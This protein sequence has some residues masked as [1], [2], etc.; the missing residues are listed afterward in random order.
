MSAAVPGNTAEQP[1]SSAQLSHSSQPSVWTPLPNLHPGLVSTPIS[2]QLVNQQLVMA[3]L[4]NQQYAVNRLLAQQ[5]LNQQYLN[6]PPPVS[7]SMNKPLE[8]QL[9]TNTEVSFEI[10]QWYTII[11][12]FQNQRYYL[13]HHGKLKDNSGLEV[14]VAEYKEEELLKDLEES[15]QDKN[16]NTL[17]SVKLEEEL[18][19]EG[20]TD[21]NADLK[22]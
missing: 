12:F 15:V 14:D 11:K 4:L 5:S 2:P 7:R 6:H 3:Q 19:V 18:S 9:S 8:R 10:Y 13:K 20:N 1:P 16:A 22:D 17:F 21:I